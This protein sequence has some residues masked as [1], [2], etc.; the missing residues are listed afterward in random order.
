MIKPGRLA[1]VR[2]Q[3]LQRDRLLEDRSPSHGSSHKFQTEE[4]VLPCYDVLFTFS[5]EFPCHRNKKKNTTA[6]SCRFTRAKRSSTKTIT[7]KTIQA[8]LPIDKE[9]PT[10]IRFS[11]TMFT[12]VRGTHKKTR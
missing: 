1:T 11:N 9:K 3:S 7:T 10:R 8:A 5:G 6:L 4:S 12:V 2:L